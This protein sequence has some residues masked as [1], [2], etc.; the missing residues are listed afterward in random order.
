MLQRAMALNGRLAHIDS[1]E[2]CCRNLSVFPGRGTG[3]ED[4]RPGLCILGFERRAVI[5]FHITTD[6]V[7][8]MRILY[9]GRD[10][11]TAFP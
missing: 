3:R 6:A 9:G 1:I 11:E 4:L 2:Q 7:T 8:I 5:A 10:V